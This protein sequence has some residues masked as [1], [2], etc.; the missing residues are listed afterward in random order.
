MVIRLV[1]DFREFIKVV[2]KREVGKSGSGWGKKYGGF[3]VLWPL[4]VLGCISVVVKG[5]SVRI[6]RGLGLCTIG[7]LG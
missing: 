3:R 6:F 4:F 1:T 5:V 7:T 2:L